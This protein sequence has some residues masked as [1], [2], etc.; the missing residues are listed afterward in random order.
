V[1]KSGKQI[2]YSFKTLLHPPYTSDVPSKRNG[3]QYCRHV[4]MK[5]F[6]PRKLG[7]G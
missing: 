4:K 1:G 3:K 6:E 5:I 2:F 7:G